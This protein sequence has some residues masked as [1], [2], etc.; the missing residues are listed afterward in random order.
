MEELKTKDYLDTKRLISTGQQEPGV[1]ENTYVKL[2]ETIDWEDGQPNKGNVRYCTLS[3]CWGTQEMGQQKLDSKNIDEYKKKGIKLSELPKTFR[4]A[5]EF[6]SRLPRVGFIWIDSL[7]IKQG[8]QE[9]DDWLIQSACMD[10]VYSESFLNISATAS[11]N[12]NEG[13]FFTRQPELLL[14]DEVILNIDGI[15]GVNKEERLVKRAHNL[16]TPKSQPSR[17]RWLQ[18]FVAYLFKLLRPFRTFP[19]SVDGLDLEIPPSMRRR[20]HSRDRLR[21]DDVISIRDVSPPRVRNETSER[22]NF[23]NLRR[24]ILLDVSHWTEN[25]DNAPVNR[26]GWVLQERLMAP[27]VLHFCKDQIAW[28]CSE[29]DASEGQPQGIP[30]LQLTSDGIVGESR[31]KGLDVTIDGKR[32]R[33]IRLETLGG[34]NDPD[35]NLRPQIYALELWR[36]IVEVYSKTSISKCVL[37]L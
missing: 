12:S 3:H 21:S 34:L 9:M 7:C 17:F 15:P 27:R 30:N 5:I 19:R 10:Q 13:L 18:D 36:R 35:K 11:S 24:C 25:V 29:F 16:S 4:D 22:S 32:L 20:L 6:A 37:R 33:Q 14:E 26:R 23:K 1:I 8:P 28:E 2:V 31:L